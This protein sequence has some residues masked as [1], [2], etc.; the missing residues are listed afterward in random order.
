MSCILRVVWVSPRF[1][2]NK[3]S[4]AMEHTEQ[5]LKFHMKQGNVMK[6][7]REHG[8]QERWIGFIYWL[9]LL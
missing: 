1:Q 8:A 7:L 5:C 6:S 3:T 2:G 9:S 4:F